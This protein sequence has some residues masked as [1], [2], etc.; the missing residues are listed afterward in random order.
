MRKNINS[1][2]CPLF[3]D[4]LN[5]IVDYIAFELKNPTAAER[6]IGDVETAIN[7]RLFVL[8]LSNHIILCVKENILIT[9]Y[10]YATSLYFM[11]SLMM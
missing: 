6:L 4:D 8:K 9:E 5:E 1:A 2:F 7:K 3:E 10:R 11:S